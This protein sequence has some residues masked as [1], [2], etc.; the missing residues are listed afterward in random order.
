MEMDPVVALAEQLRAAERSLQSAC[1]NWPDEKIVELRTASL[2]IR[3]MLESTEPTSAMGAAELIAIA[4]DRLATTEFPY[5]EDLKSVGLR[6]G[7]GRR[8]LSDLIWLRAVVTALDGD[9]CGERGKRA[10]AL[11]RAA[12]EGAAKP[13]I[14][15]RAA[16]VQEEVED[17]TPAPP[18]TVG[19]MRRFGTNPP[20]SALSS[21]PDRK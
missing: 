10:A 4:A 12:I 5:I 1:T 3:R 21:A 15:F 20:L 11:I 13:L 2:I 19:L 14:I 7:D 18:G 6:F 17:D 16:P 9:A 8:V